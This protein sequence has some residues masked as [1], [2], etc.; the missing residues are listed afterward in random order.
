M[1]SFDIAC[2]YWPWRPQRLG[3]RSRGTQERGRRE[4]LGLWWQESHCCLIAQV[5]WLSSDFTHW[6]MARDPCM[7]LEC[8]SAQTIS[9]E[10]SPQGTGDDCPNHR[11]QCEYT[12]ICKCT[13]IVLNESLEPCFNYNIISFY[14]T[15]NTPPS[16]GDMFLQF[17]DAE[18]KVRGGGGHLMKESHSFHPVT[19]CCETTFI[20]GCITALTSSVARYHS[21]TS[22]Y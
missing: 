20:L 16:I 21:N 3:G 10:N 4:T 17:G 11:L 18:H 2:N 1:Y 13:Q 5:A 22:S 7:L 12:H 6:E 15:Y 9:S 8:N 14:L 19:A